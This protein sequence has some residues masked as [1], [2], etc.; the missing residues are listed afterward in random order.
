MFFTVFLLV[1]VTKCHEPHQKPCKPW[2]FRG[3]VTMTNKLQLGGRWHL[4]FFWETPLMIYLDSDWWY[5]TILLLISA[6]D[7]EE[8]LVFLYLKIFCLVTQT[9]YMYTDDMIDAHRFATTHDNICYR[10]RQTQGN[11][12]NCWWNVSWPRQHCF[13]ISKGFGIDQS[14]KIFNQVN[15]EQEIQRGPPLPG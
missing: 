13:R 6:N 10:T 9:L 4:R 14:P 7:V 15:H 12:S 8:I 2:C 5:G 11:P 3:M 1:N